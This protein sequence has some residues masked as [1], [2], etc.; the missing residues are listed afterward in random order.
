MAARVDWRVKWRLYQRGGGRVNV[1]ENAEEFAWPEE[2]TKTWRERR[3]T[4]CDWSVTD[5]S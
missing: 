2:L 3:D 1:R 5:R 4:L